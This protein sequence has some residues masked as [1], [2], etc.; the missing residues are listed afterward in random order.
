MKKQKRILPPKVSLYFT[1][2]RGTDGLKKIETLAKR[3]DLS[4]SVIGGM[5]ITAGLPQ[6]EKSLKALLE[7]EAKQAPRI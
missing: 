5:A 2:V 7:R 4:V 3:F 1:G 6:V